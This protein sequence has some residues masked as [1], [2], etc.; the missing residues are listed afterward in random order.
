MN[1]ISG[2][3]VKNYND[4]MAVKDNII[5]GKTYRFTILTERLVRIEYSPN[6][7]FVDS[8]SERVIFR[9]FP[10]TKFKVNNTDTLIQITTLY[11]TLNYVKEKMPNIWKCQIL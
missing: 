9:K 11:F 1:T 10:Q 8:P 6:G 7:E 4:G 2:S 5:I 3:F